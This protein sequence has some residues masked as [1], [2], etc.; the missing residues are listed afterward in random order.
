MRPLRPMLRRMTD[1][2]ILWTFSLALQLAVA[3]LKRRGASPG[4]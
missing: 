4:C 2:L 1:R 3:V